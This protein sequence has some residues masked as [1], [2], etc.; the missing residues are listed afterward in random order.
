MLE[1]SNLTK[2]K[3]SGR[4]LENLAEAFLENH[5]IEKAEISLVLIGDKRSR[6]LNKKY[7]KKDYLTDVLS[8]SNPN[9]KIGKDNFLG[10]IFINLAEVNRLKKYQAMFLELE[11]FGAD[12]F[13]RSSKS[14]QEKY[15]LSFI[16]IHGLLHLIGF[17]DERDR[18]R[19]KM[20]RL[21]ATF[22]KCY[23]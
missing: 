22:L 17:N 7:R 2:R 13:L 19:Q 15:L 9:F 23:N 12:K 10:E 3:F 4:D 20:L 18:D 16:F 14:A 6:T 8:F 5:K 11:D 21:G 1:I